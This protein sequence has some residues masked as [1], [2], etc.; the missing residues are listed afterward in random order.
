MFSSCIEK[1]MWHEIGD[2]LELGQ[3]WIEVKSLG[4]KTWKF[5]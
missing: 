2:S 1:D 5:T 4:P 3:I